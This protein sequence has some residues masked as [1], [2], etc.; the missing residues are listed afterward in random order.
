M[1]MLQPKDTLKQMI[2]FNKSAYEN[3]SKHL[4]MLHEQMEKMFN[5]YMDQAVGIPEEGRKAAKEWARMS[6]KGFDDFK[7]LMED[8]YKKVEA[9]FQ[10]NEPKEPK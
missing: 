3:A 8:N 1:K 5:Q 9:F 6:K 10:E 4:N 2:E 7:K